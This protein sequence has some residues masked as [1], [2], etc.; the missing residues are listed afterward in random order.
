MSCLLN[1]QLCDH[2]RAQ[3]RCD[4]GPSSS[5]VQVPREGALSSVRL[6]AAHHILGCWCMSLAAHCRRQ[7][8]T[9]HG[10]PFYQQ[11]HARKVR[12]GSVCQLFCQPCQCAALVI[13]K[14]ILSS[15]EYLWVVRSQQRCRQYWFKV[16]TLAYKRQL[17]IAPICLSAKANPVFID[18][19]QNASCSLGSLILPW[20]VLFL[21][22]ML[23]R[24]IF[25]V[26]SIRG[27]K[28]KC[29]PISWLHNRYF[30]LL[31]FPL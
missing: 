21:E 6:S 3:L 1:Q 11:A 16:T 22:K 27:W 25:L 12:P 26:F 9:K 4:C 30:I 10:V 8:T 14:I 28:L 18:H 15:Y 29:Q 5:K 23:V 31:P 13:K 24:L 7:G 20:L 17:K 2:S 19:V